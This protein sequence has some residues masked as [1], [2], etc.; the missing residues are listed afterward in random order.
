MC[1]REACRTDG[2]VAYDRLRHDLL[3]FG[4]H[5]WLKAAVGFGVEG[6]NGGAAWRGG[7]GRSAQALSGTAA[8]CARGESASGKSK[9][10]WTQYRSYGSYGT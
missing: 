8:I 10:T 4:R 7:A 6:W 2:P 5:G 3:D 9:A 1:G